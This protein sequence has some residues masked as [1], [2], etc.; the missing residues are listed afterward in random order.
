MLPDNQLVNLVRDLLSTNNGR[1]LLNRHGYLPV[2]QP[3]EP[4]VS[5][6]EVIAVLKLICV[7]AGVVCPIIETM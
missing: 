5:V 4:E 1:L 7:G 3:L 2:L 6:T